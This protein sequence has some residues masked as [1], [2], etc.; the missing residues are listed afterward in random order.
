VSATFD[1]SRYFVLDRDHDVQCVTCHV[2]NDYRR[3]TC[4]GCHEHA[5][6]N[7]R[8]EQME[9]GIRD[10][11]DCA[12]FHRSADEVDTEMPGRDKGNRDRVGMRHCPTDG[13]HWT[14]DSGPTLLNKVCVMNS[15]TRPALVGALRRKS[16]G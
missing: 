8:R 11:R 10:F 6:Q 9:E 12:E 5:P 4:Y 3:Y 2:H 13:A 14:T 16:P 15:E 1:H 7:I